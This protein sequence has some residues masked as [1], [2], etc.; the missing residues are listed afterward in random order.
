[1]NS[2]INLT[3]VRGYQVYVSFEPMLGFNTRRRRKSL[4]SYGIAE[5]T[6]PCVLNKWV[7][8][9]ENERLARLFEILTK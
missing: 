3:Y 2:L 1:M 7:K 6:K 4:Y 9:G 8:T 5:F